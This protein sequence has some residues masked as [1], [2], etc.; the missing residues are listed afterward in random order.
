MSDGVA[1]RQ[2]SLNVLIDGAAVNGATRLELFQNGSFSADRFVVSM[3]FSGL[4]GAAY[5]AGL[6]MPLVSISIADSGISA[7]TG[8]TLITGQVDNVEIDFEARIAT[9][10]GRDLSARLIDAEVN[11]SFANQTASDIAVSFA[12]AAGL[13][14]N[15]VPTLT[16]VGQ[17]YELS[18]TR[19]ALG[20]H[21]RSATQWDLLASLAEV[22]AYVLSVTGTTLNFVPLPV[23]V[24]PVTLIYG[25]DLV[26]LKIDRAAS[27]STAQVTV[28]SWNTRLKVAHESPQGNGMSTTLIR[29]NLMPDQV[30]S[31]A[32]AKQ[33]ELVAQTCFLRAIMPGETSL[34]PQTWI[35]L[36]GTSTSLDGNYLIQAI[37][38]YVDAERGFTQTIEAYAAG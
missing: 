38:R 6:A 37:E 25:Q 20:L 17:Y 21:T 8:S 18:H 3:A 34:V 23:V 35:N 13:T 33:A 36:Q 16:P 15:A 5:Y 9:L 12:L 30:L 24:A 10:S 4:D 29:P 7:D 27:L 2:I 19:T 14:P 28:R 32:S 22:E 11:Q 26:S 31:I 1:A